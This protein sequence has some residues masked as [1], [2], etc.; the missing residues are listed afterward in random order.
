[1]RS[2]IALAV[3]LALASSTAAFADTMMK[4][5]PMPSTMHSKMKHHARHS[6]RKPN[7]MHGAMHGSMNAAP[8][9]MT[10]PSPQP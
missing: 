7:A 2:R 6:A 4:A 3:M 5:G 10:S 1:M 9:A 8:G